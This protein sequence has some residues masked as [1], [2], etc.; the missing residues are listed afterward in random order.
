M[1]KTYSARAL[2]ADNGRAIDIISSEHLPWVVHFYLTLRAT[3]DAFFLADQVQRHLQ[4]LFESERSLDASARQALE[5]LFRGC[6]EIILYS[7]HIYALLRPKIGVKRMVRLHPEAKHFEEVS[8]GHYLFVKDAF[9]QGLDVASKPGLVVDFSPYFHEYPKIQ[10]P[11]EL[12]EGIF[13]LNRQ[14]S[15]Q[16][17]QRPEVFR[18]AIVRFLQMCQMDK[19]NLLANSHLD[20]PDMLM[21]ELDTVRALLADHDA[22]QPCTE[23]AHELRVHGFEPG[24]GRTAGEVARN[25]TLLA[26]LMQSPDPVRF[27][28]F[29]GRL[30]LVRTVLMVSPH[31]WFAQDGVLGR[32]DTG[33]QVT[34]VLDQARALERQ[35]QQN[36]AAAGINATPRIVILTRLIPEAE[37]TTC[38]VPRER[39]HGSN[40]CWILRV[41]FHDAFGQVVPY[42]ISRFHIWPYLENFAASARQEVVTEMLGTPD[43]IIGHYSDGNLV[44]HWLAENLGATHCASVH[45]LEKTKYL[46]SDMHWAAM[47]SDYRFSLQFTADMISYNAADYIIT[48]SY[49]EIAGTDT[50]MGMFESYETFSMPGLYRVH[51]GMDPQLAR[52]NIVP[53]GVSEE[54][55]FPFTE[56]S[57]RV[58]GVRRQLE[59]LLFAP[60]PGPGALG[61]LKNPEL[62]AI[63]A[64]SRVDRVK[65][66]PG[67]VEAYGKS[68][69]LRA[70]ANLMILSSLLHARESEDQE[71][72]EQLNRIHALIERY[73]LHGHIRWA[74]SRLDKV[75][76]GEIYRL[77]ADR[78]GVFAQPALM[79]TFGLTVIEA[80]SCGLPVVVTCFG[81]PA[82]IVVA[83]ES[84]EI[85][86]PNDH[87][88]FATALERVLVDKELW[89]ARSRNGIAR[90]AEAFTWQVHAERILRLANVYTYWNYLDVMNRQALDQYLHTLYYTV[91]RPRALAL[92]EGH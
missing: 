21:Q 50:E 23:L 49:R 77:L 52:Y 35:M 15:G 38:N 17:Y 8:R 54:Y 55:F 5:R 16:M 67:L 26:Q 45:A 80:M 2:A 32:P 19:I 46:F 48:S 58:E 4:A 41:P 57:R 82:E 74:A 76:T 92:L 91:Y 73:D 53:P 22:D 72:I 31:G 14:L 9:V 86:N 75:Q 37:G 25:L 34:Y 81:G 36:F 84:G 40:N 63:F 66:L 70:S 3:G 83:G 43:L 11:S 71:E 42:W 61:Q 89:E 20:S 56:E 88:A 10:E 27:E 51:S 30:P 68:A 60:E 1:P 47:E 78:R 90:V 44:A 62:P 85:V 33:G 87:E 7:N 29:L 6:Q 65:N 18:G 59:K 24:W 39:V 13:F 79:E 64:M 69:S 28:Q 12:G